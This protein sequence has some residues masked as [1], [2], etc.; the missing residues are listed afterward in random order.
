MQ[1]EGHSLSPGLLR[2]S[3]ADLGVQLSDTQSTQLVAF[4]N[5][6]VKWNRVHNLT[7]LDKPQDILSHHLLDSL[8]IV[9]ELER[10]AEGRVLRILDVGSGGGLPGVPIAIA[11]PAMHVT[12]IDRVQKKTAFLQQV[13]VELGLTN[14]EVTH[15]RVEEYRAAPFDVITSRAFAALEE[16]VRVTSHLLAGRGCWLAMKGVY[17][18]EEI[19]ALPST[20]K[21]VRAVKLHVPLLGAERHLLVLRPS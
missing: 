2:R 17:P 5:L 9:P 14:V 20:V 16:M 1:L 21:L 13:C 4:A 10:C 6:L 12:L 11:L 19:S 7:A 3:S 8:S 18:T 15:A